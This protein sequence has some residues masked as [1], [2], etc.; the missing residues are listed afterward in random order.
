VLGYGVERVE[1]RRYYKEHTSEFDRP[2]QLTW[3]EIRVNIENGQTKAAEE[4]AAALLKKVDSGSDFATVAK[5]ESKGP[6]ADQG[7]LWETSPGS[8]AMPEINKALEVMQPGQISNLIVT[9]QAVHI[10]KLESSREAGPARFDEVQT[11]I[12]NKLRD[13][14]LAQASV[15][16]VKDLH[17]QAVIRTI[18]DDMP[19]LQMP[20][21]PADGQVQRTNAAATP[22][23]P[24]PLAQPQSPSLPSPQTQASSPVHAGL[25]HT[26]SDKPVKEDL[27]PTLAP[28][29]VVPPRGVMSGPSAPSPL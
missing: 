16:F 2:A 12:Q 17:R 20:G 19:A 10:L 3:R 18:F 23:T 4:K 22:V 8:F 29:G 27:P 25:P 28:A 9:A 13:E 5:Q 6:T 21:M 1:M 15:G 24:A 26:L 14:K 7:G 11:V